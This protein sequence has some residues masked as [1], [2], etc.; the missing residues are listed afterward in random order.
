MMEINLEWPVA[1]HYVVRKSRATKGQRAIYVAENAAIRLRRPLDENPSLYAEFAKLDG[2]EKACL[3][4]A[5]RYGT[6]LFDPRNPNAMDP[7]DTERLRIWRGF[8]E[9]MRDIIQRC[10][11]SRANPKEAF[12]QFGKKDRA[13]VGVEL[14]LSIKSSNSPA[15]L[16]VRAASLITGMEL[17]AIQAI[18]LEGRKSVQCIECSRP[19]L[20]GGGARRSQSKFCSARCKDSYHNRLKAQVRR[21]HA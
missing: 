8:I 5:H 13:V 7:A 14:S 18:L 16:E 17:Q 9:N 19:F 1:S 4:F 12:R 20:I 15:T 2:S 21:D 10:E 3:N 6:L 11:L